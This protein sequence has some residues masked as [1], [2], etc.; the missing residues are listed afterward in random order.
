[1]KAYTYYS[2][3]MAHVKILLQTNRQGKNY[4][5]M[6]YRYGGIKR[7][8]RKLQ[9]KQSKQELNTFPNDKF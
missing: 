7:R 9:E 6:I 5:P 8:K 2:K 4:L 1:M 3:F